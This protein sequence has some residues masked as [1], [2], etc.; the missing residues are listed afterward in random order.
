[1]IL[2]RRELILMVLFSY[3]FFSVLMFFTLKN[4]VR[5]RKLAFLLQAFRGSNFILSTPLKERLVFE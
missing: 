3:S 4:W 1:M 2:D 5:K